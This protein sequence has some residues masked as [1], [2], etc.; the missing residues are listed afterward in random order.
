MKKDVTVNTRILSLKMLICGFCVT[1]FTV[2]NRLQWV[3]FHTKE[4]L[5]LTHRTG[6]IYCIILTTTAF[7]WSDK[8]IWLNVHQSWKLD[9]T[10]EIILLK[11]LW[12]QHPVPQQKKNPPIWTL[13]L[14]LTD[15]SSGKNYMLLKELL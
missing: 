9:K 12:C 6:T 11:E 13:S 3:S 7:M 5:F 8:K 2:L 15:T 1:C 10:T 14:S 4:I